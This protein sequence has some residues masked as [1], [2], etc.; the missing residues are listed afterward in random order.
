MSHNDL[1]AIIDRDDDLSSDW[2]KEIIGHLLDEIDDIQRPAKPLVYIAGPYSGD[3]VANVR[4]AVKIGLELW[5]TGHVAVLIPHLTL[6]ADLVAPMEHDDW[7]RYDFDQIV[8]CDAVLRISGDSHGADEEV[9]FACA[10]Q[11]P[12]FHSGDDLIKW[13]TS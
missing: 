6:L 2:A 3:V 1:R 12:V 5:R 13:V 8:H 9:L 4:R 7:Y 11:L 10:L